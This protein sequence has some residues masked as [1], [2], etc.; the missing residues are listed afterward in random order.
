[1]N[2]GSNAQMTNR[3]PGIGQSSGW[4]LQCFFQRNQA[5]FHNYMHI[6]INLQEHVSMQRMLDSSDKAFDQAALV[7]LVNGK[8]AQDEQYQLAWPSWWWLNLSST[9]FI[10]HCGLIDHRKLMLKRDAEGAIHVFL[11]IVHTHSSQRRER[12]HEACHKM[13]PKRALAG[14][15][16]LVLS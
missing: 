1:M 5:I 16:L 15:Y 9:G 3:N 6:C 10:G 2:A 4:E 7:T 8:P 12:G 14:P 13:L 11:W